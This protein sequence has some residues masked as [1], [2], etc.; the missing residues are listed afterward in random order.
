[1]KINKRSLI[2]IA[3]LALVLGMSFA[4]ANLSAVYYGP[5]YNRGGFLSSWRGLYVFLSTNYSFTRT[6]PNCNNCP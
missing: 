2:T 5:R 3:T 1:M 4:P 6:G